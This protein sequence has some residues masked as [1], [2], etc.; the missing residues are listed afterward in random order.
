LLIAACTRL[1]FSSLNLSDQA[2][3]TMAVRATP[4][5][6]HLDDAAHE[7]GRAER[8]LDRTG[9]RLILAE[10]HSA[11]TLLNMATQVESLAISQR[12]IDPTLSAVELGYSGLLVLS[13]V[14]CGLRFVD[15]AAL[16]ELRALKE[17]VLRHNFL[18]RIPPDVFSNNSK[19]LTIDL[20]NNLLSCVSAAGVDLP[21]W[22]NFLKTVLIFE[23][24]PITVKQDVLCNHLPVS[25][26]N[27]AK[28]SRSAC[29]I[30]PTR[31][32]YALD[33]ASYKK[34]QTGD[35]VGC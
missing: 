13:L 22:P 26:E 11:L 32:T 19:L 25:A 10:L 14:D 15:R 4:V 1:A 21:R 27:D 7:R 5:N 6:L 18:E 35:F 23:G 9:A 30:S 12:S 24:N 33:V 2:A 16:R 31:A 3:L 28:V 29:E 17:L 34:P 8:K 20:R